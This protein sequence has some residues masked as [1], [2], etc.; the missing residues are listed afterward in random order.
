MKSRVIQLFKRPFV[1]SVIIMVT[2][3]VGAQIVKMLLSP[4]IT[5]IYGPEAFGIMGLFHSIIQ[6]IIPIASLTYPIAIV[7]PKSDLNAKK[8]MRLSINIAF[9]MSIISLLII[10]YFNNAFIEIFNLQQ[11]SIFLYLI[12]IVIIFSAFMQVG[13]QWFIR[14]KQFGI[15][16][17]ATF[18]QSTIIELG[19]VIVGIFYPSAIV[20]VLFTTVNNGLKALLMLIFGRKT[21]YK[22]SEDK[23]EKQITIKELAKKY[24]DFPLLRAPQAF[25]EAITQSL[26]VVLLTMLFNPASAG[27]YTLCRTVLALPTSLLGKSVGDVF[28]PRIN[29]AAIKREKITTL[30]VRSVLA[31]CFMGIVPYGL[32]ILFGPWLF[33]LIFGQDWLIAGEYAR[34]I[35]LSSFFRFINEP[36]LRTLPVLSAQLFHLISTILHTLSR[37]LALIIGFYLFKSDVIAVALLGIVGGVIN[38]FLIIMTLILSRKFERKNVSH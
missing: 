20:L 19:K 3:T 5:R 18:Y 27:F 34:W 11:M 35:A 38:L 24:R 31:L 33:S 26:P 21:K 23:D 30:I 10:F 28:Y 36:C 13:E 8:I 6:I 22:I 29:E 16:A 2:G 17:K 32:V 25:I 4:F 12:P 15:N 9:L 14:T 7:L 1:Q 37:I